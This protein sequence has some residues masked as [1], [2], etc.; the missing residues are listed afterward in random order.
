[1]GRTTINALT[2]RTFKKGLVDLASKDAD[3]ASIMRDFGPPPFWHR[4]PGFPTLIRIILEQQVSLAS[5]KAT[6]YRLLETA[7][8]LS[9]ES[10]LKLSDKKLKSI[11]FSRQKAA[12]GRNLSLAVLEGDLDFKALSGMEDETVRSHLIRIKGIGPWTADIYLLTALRRPDVWPGGDLAIVEAVRR[13]KALDKRPSSET[14]DKIS[15]RWKPYRAVAAR[16]LWHYYLV[17]TRKRHLSRPGGVRNRLQ[18]SK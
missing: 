11:G 18:S 15:S 3:L 10:F 2:S 5:G 13:I 6:Y 1:M 4:E 8:P 7:S 17:S 12:Y 9:P 14:L 16:V